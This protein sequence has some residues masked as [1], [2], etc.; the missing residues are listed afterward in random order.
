[1][2]PRDITNRVLR[3]PV[4]SIY[5]RAGGISGMSVGMRWVVAGIAVWLA[6]V[7]LAS[8]HSFLRIQALRHELRSSG[9]DLAHVQARNDALENQLHDPVGQAEHAEQM[10]RRQGMAKQ[11]ELIY[12][13]DPVAKDSTAR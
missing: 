3:R 7:T 11:G 6:W 12:R 2:K 8:D 9:Q 10:L 4:Q 5:G 13:F 1:M